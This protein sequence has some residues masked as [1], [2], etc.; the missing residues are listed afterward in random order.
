MIIQW[1]AP[2]LGNYIRPTLVMVNA[3][4]VNPLSNFIMLAVWIGAGLLG[5]IIAGTKKGAFVVGLMTWLTCLGILAFCVVQLITT[6]INLNSIPP[7]PEG[8]SILDLLS[9]PLVQDIFDELLVA[10]SSGGGGPDIGSIIFSVAIWAL[11]PVI[12]VI[13]A[14]IIGATIRPKEDF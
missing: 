9:V 3:V 6:G 11:T 13:V 10:L 8:G 5:G 7:I 12:V 4:L 1:L 2:E 14:G